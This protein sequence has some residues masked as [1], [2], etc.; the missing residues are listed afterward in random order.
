MTF[1][2]EPTMIDAQA[3]REYLAREI[4][5]IVISQWGPLACVACRG[6]GDGSSY[7]SYNYS[8]YCGSCRGTGRVIV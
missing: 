4:A 8:Y 1:E 2:L 5:E 7:D 3:E 6:T